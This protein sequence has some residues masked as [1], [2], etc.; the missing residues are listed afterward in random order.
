[1][2]INPVQIAMAANALARPVIPQIR[3]ASIFWSSEHRHREG[4][5]QILGGRPQRF[6]IRQDFVRNLSSYLVPDVG[7]EIVCIQAAALSSVGRLIQTP[8]GKRPSAWLACYETIWM[9]SVRAFHD[10]VTRIENG[11]RAAVVDHDGR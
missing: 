1:M 10:R 6:A 4:K 2:R 9:R 11:I 7:L 3:L 5:P 8:C